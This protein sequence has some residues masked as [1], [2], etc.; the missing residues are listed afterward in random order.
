MGFIIFNITKVVEN[1]EWPS[2]LCMCMTVMGFVIVN[3]TQ[4]VENHEW[5]SAMAEDSEGPMLEDRTSQLVR[6]L[7]PPDSI[8][9]TL[10]DGLKV[11]TFCS[12]CSRLLGWFWDGWGV[13]FVSSFLFWGGEWEEGFDGGGGGGCAEINTKA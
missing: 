6:F 8:I 7:F 13:C 5:P 12:F 9:N 1:Q 11:N 10:K 3:V 4:V 2:A